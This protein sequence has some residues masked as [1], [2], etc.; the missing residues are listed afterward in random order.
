MSET[1]KLVYRGEVLEGQH[2][3]VVRRR[4]GESAGI[5][6][7]ALDKLFSGKPVVLK[8]EADTATAAR[9]QAV[10]K[11]AGARL[12]VL[13]SETGNDP[14]PPSAGKGA[15]PRAART[16]PPGA[17]A[18]GTEPEAAEGFELFPAGSPLL[19]DSERNPFEPRD[20][21]TSGLSLEGARFTA[22]EPRS[23][24][25]GPDVSH[26]SMADVGADLR[27]G[28]EPTA[29]PVTA[30]DLDVAAVGSTLGPAGKPTTPAIDVAR[31]TFEV[32]PA[33]SD[34]G[35]RKPLAPPAAP[36]VSHLSLVSRPED[37]D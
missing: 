33:G 32:A 18:T 28:A 13:P 29:A 16:R 27:P 2:P 4:L 9:L 14:A 7:E 26:L 1:Y 5:A 37:R 8:Q 19:R 6:D 24:A 25:G 22:S 30:P 31:V 21:D 12:R 10:F 11:K 23:E 35:Q 17:E 20:V 15:P 34:L 36:D 3:A